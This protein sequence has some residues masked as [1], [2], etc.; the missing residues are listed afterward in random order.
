MSPVEREKTT[1]RPASDEAMDRH[2]PL[3]AGLLILICWVWIAVAAGGA[4]L[5]ARPALG[6]ALLAVPVGF[7][8]TY[9]VRWVAARSAHLMIGGL[10]SAGNIKYQAQFSI[11]ESLVARG[12][13][14]EAAESFK[15]HL[16]E[17]PDDIPARYRLATLH[18]RERHDPAAAE[19]EFLALRRRPLD[20]GTALLVSNHLIDIYQA[21][22]Q[23]GRLMAELT[24]MMKERPGTTMAEGAAK[25]LD[26][27]RRGE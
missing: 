18:L 17:H 16:A 24:R 15:A 4:G 27:L 7:G 21:T 11:Q 3:Q 25:L 12:R 22:A 6:L 1:H 20:P 9:G 2:A 8:V 5:A 14:D 19:E 13:F 10:S 23:R 26:E